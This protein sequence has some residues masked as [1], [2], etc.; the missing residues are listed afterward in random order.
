MR[1]GIDSMAAMVNAAMGGA[2]GAAG[3]VG[4]SVESA[5]ASIGEGLQY[6][7]LAVVGGLVVYGLIQSRAA[8]EY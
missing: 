4:A 6:A 7:A 5:A 1:E 2:G 3:G 8:V